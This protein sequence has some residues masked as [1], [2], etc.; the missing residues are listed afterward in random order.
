VIS[1]IKYLA[2]DSAFIYYE[3][4]E[5][6]SLSEIREGVPKDIYVLGIVETYVTVNPDTYEPTR[7][8]MI[9]ISSQ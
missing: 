5:H 1:H 6:R 9:N 7:Y 8:Y 2:N 3:D 4:L